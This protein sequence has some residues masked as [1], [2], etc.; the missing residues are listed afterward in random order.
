[1]KKRGFTLIEILISLAIIALSFLLIQRTFFSLQKDIVNTEKKIEGNEKLLNFLFHFK[2]EI[3][4]ICD[5]ENVYFNSKEINF[6]TVFP[7]KDCPVEL[8]YKIKNGILLRK[9]KNIFTGYEFTLPVFNAE[10]INFFFFVN[11]EWKYEAEENKK[12]EAIA[13]EVL[14]QDFKIFYPIYLR[15]EKKN[16]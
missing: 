15:R 6:K 7:D 13:I 11:N 10:D 12:P 1:M 4:G 3:E 2:S 5:W 16:E 8:I 14:L 9:E